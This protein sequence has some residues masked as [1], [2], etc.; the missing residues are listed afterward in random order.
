M[1]LFERRSL[2]VMST[3][4]T[5]VRVEPSSPELRATAARAAERRGVSAH[6][7]FVRL[8]LQLP[9]DASADAMIGA[10]LVAE[11]ADRLSA[12]M[13]E[14]TS[15]YAAWQKPPGRSE[16]SPSDLEVDEVD[17]TT[18]RLVLERFHY[19]RSFR[20]G[21]E[22]MGGVLRD[23]NDERLVAL[24]TLSAL[25]VPTIAERLPD[26]VAATETM[27]LSRV[28]AFDWAPRNTLSFL[29]GRLTRVLR[30]RPTPPRLLITYVNPNVGFTGASYRAANWVLW[31]REVGTR[32][33]YFDG[34]YTTDRELARTFG[35]SDPA[36]LREIVGDRIA[37][38][39][40]TLQPLN[41]YA[42]PL[43]TD[44]RAALS[45]GEPIELPRPIP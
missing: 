4:A 28:F 7:V 33:A 8:L 27:V 25:D 30:R 5:V 14:A 13:C 17:E 26:G 12:E 42:Q 2:H 37:F 29:M 34:R 20:L 3:M 18:A 6:E 41:L 11:E 40:M 36:A 19:L 23:E 39:R 10:R 22:H 9:R 31:A 1:S 44:L 38:S 24:L 35:T 15:D 45:T 43:E 16:I 32:Y 21:S